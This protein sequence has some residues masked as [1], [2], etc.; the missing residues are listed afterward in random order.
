MQTVS[1]T[2]THN[3]TFEDLSIASLINCG[4]AAYQWNEKHKKLVDYHK[5][6]HRK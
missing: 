4:I 5:I 3:D 2:F 1:S 6:T